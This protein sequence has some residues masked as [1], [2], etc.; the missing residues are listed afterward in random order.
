MYKEFKNGIDIL[1]G[2]VVFKLIKYPKGYF[3][4]LLMNR[5]D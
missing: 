4:Q 1:V 2:Q 5:L 3:D